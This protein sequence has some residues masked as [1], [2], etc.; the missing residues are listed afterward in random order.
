VSDLIPLPERI[1]DSNQEID[2][3]E[4][5]IHYISATLAPLNWL[6]QRPPA[7]KVE[8]NKLFDELAFLQ[9]KLTIA[10]QKLSSLLLLAVQESIVDLD[11][12]IKTLS[13]TASIQVTA[14]QSLVDSSTKQIVITEKLLESSNTQSSTTKDLLESTNTQSATTKDLLNTSKSQ[15]ETTEKLL[16]S[17][18]AQM[19]IIG[20]LE[21]STNNLEFLTIF[22]VITALLTLAYN[23][24]NTLTGDQA[25][26]ARAT[27]EL[28][29]F[30]TVI[31]V[32]VFW[33]LIRYQSWKASQKE[34]IKV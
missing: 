4:D 11:S 8:P 25:T 3:L 32:I 31:T 24:G 14:T 2:Q 15:K 29:T 16:E 5:R 34:K 10:Q 12:S 33:G 17:T 7:D 26:Q 30:A 20:K 13:H 19:G 22:V 9:R 21:R 1:D 28:I 27:L 23:F 18:K 6:H